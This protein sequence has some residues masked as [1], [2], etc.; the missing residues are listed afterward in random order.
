MFRLFFRFIALLIVFAIVRYLVTTVAR[1]FSRAKNPQAARATEN[2]AAA[3][4]SGCEL[5]RDPVCGTFV[6]TNTSVK[7][8]INGEL[9]HFCSVACRDKFKGA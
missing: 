6:P 2:P 4:A 5:K 9:V 1:T 8:T 7:E 3:S